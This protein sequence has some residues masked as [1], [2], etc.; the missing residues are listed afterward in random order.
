ME[1]KKI[2]NDKKKLIS[3]ISYLEKELN[4]N[5]NNLNQTLIKIKIIKDKIEFLKRQKDDL[6]TNN[7]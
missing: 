2:N 1:N 5:K 6:S 3:K 7:K 4:I